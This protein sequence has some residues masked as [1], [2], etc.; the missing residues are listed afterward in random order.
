MKDNPLVRLG[1]SLVL[2]SIMVLAFRFPATSGHGYLE[3]IFA[4]LFPALLF[5]SVFRGRRLIWTF[6]TLLLGFGTLFYWVPGTIAVKGNLPY[7][8]ALLGSLLLVAWESL[9]FFAVVAFA[10]FLGYRRGPWSAAVGAGLGML[11]WELF[12]FH[13]YTWSWGS[14]LGGL[15][16]LARSAAFLASYGL[17]AILWGGATLMGAWLAEGHYRKVGLVPVGLASFLIL[18]GTTWYLLPR[19][20]ERTLDLVMIQPN[21]DP[22][23]RRPGMEEDMWQRSDAILKARG[24]PRKGVATLLLWPESSVLGRDDLQ[25]NP[26]LHMEAQKR[27]VAWLFGTEG[28]LLNLVRGE[29]SLVRALWAGKPMVWQIYPQHDAAHHHK[30]EAFLNMLDA[31]PALRVLSRG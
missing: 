5:E 10:R 26:R 25:P 13:V 7:A 30:L 27:G 1:E 8:L 14:A 17:S 12:G 20:P 28:G 23:V 22:G 24:L 9:G 3:A 6:L 18:L 29:D 2:A 4:L 31:G 11:L 16:V 21:F 19:R 15:P